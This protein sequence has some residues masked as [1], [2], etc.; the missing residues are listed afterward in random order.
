MVKGFIFDFD[1][2]LID[3]N[4]YHFRSWQ[5]T[6]EKFN[7]NFNINIY[8]KTKGLN[9]FESLK[10]ILNLNQNILNINE[11]EILKKKN[12]IF[13]ELIKNLSTN[14]LMPGVKNFI[15]NHND[16]HKLG[17]ASSSKNARYILKKI[18]FDHY[19]DVIV[20]GNN[21]TESKP[22]PEVFLKCAELLNLS[23]SECVVFEDS[24][25]G[26]IGA[27]KGGFHTYLVGESEFKNLAK[28]YIKDLTFYT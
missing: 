21:I 2:V 15:L 27:N 13:L 17:V 20:D 25:N 19:F 28:S 23:P 14:D 9:R 22:N 8:N 18:N 3:T 1:G 4:K 11:D 24:K 6:F 7:I 5:K 10:F 16:T 12:I 26:I